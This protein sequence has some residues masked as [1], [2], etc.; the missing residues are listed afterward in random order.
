MATP[1]RFKTSR[2]VPAHSDRHGGRCGWPR[3]RRGWS[4]RR[5]PR[6]AHP[7]SSHG[8]VMPFMSGP[9]LAAKLQSRGQAS[10][11]CLCRRSPLVRST[12]AVS[13]LPP[14]NRSS[15]SHSP[16]WPCRRRC[17]PSS[18]LSR[19]SGDPIDVDRRVHKATSRPVHS[20][21][22]IRPNG[23]RATGSA[24]GRRPARA[25]LLLF[26]AGPSGPYE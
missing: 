21:D 12:T 19:L 8:F 26:V 18:S 1:E 11:C 25:Q 15:S 24:P 2:E 20:L 13:E 16:R 5:D 9:D 7:S 3:V 17:G 14:V 22:G 23:D 10:R 4:L 6:E